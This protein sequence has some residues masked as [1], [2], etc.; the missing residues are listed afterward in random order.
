MYGKAWNPPLK[1]RYHDEGKCNGSKAVSSREMFDIDAVPASFTAMAMPNIM[2]IS[3][4]PAMTNAFTAVLKACLPA[5]YNHADSVHKSPSQK[6]R[7]RKRLSLNT[8][9]LTKDAENR[10]YA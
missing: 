10:R 8:A 6:K 9:P 4:T 1:Q 3:V 2:H 5:Y 7:R